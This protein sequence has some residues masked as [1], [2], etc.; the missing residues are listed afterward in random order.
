MNWEMAIALNVL[1]QAEKSNM[2]L[3]RWKKP[4]EKKP[5]TDAKIAASWWSVTNQESLKWPAF[6]PKDN[7]PCDAAG[8][9]SARDL[10]S[11]WL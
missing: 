10:R 9:R 11:E 1:M 3:N 2:T 5:H 4:V 7:Q 6:S 8:I